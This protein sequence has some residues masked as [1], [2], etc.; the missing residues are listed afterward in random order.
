MLAKDHKV[1]GMI[2]LSSLGFIGKLFRSSHLQQLASFFMMFYDEK[3]VDW[4]IYN[5]LDTKDLSVHLS[6]RHIFHHIGTMSSLQG[7]KQLDVD[8][9]FPRLY[10]L[11]EQK[12]KARKIIPANRVPIHPK[13]KLFSTMGENMYYSLSA[14]YNT[15]DGMYWAEAVQKSN[16]FTISFRTYQSLQSIKIATGIEEHPG[17]VIHDASLVAG[18]TTR[19]HIVNNNGTVEVIPC[20]NDII[21]GKF[22]NGTIDVQLNNTVV[23]CLS[24]IVNESQS[25]WALFSSLQINSTDTRRPTSTRRD[26]RADAPAKVQLERN[27]KL[28]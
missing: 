10:A 24:V 12:K 21:L 17:D 25:N 26:T 19:K 13:A 14:L 6:S 1:W 9:N 4:L 16:Y 3:P 22:I 20:Q 28:H 27:E 11:R 8:L 2:S 15:A 23:A 18:R 5:F 7:K